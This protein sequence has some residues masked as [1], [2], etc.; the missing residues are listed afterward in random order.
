MDMDRS[1]GHELG[2]PW[3]LTLGLNLLVVGVVLVLVTIPFELISSSGLR[4]DRLWRQHRLVMP[5]VWGVFTLFRVWDRHVRRWL[6][7]AYGLRSEVVGASRIFACVIPV[8]DARPSARV[9]EASR[10]LEENFPDVV[11][12][13]VGTLGGCRSRNGF[14]TSLTQLRS[15]GVRGRESQVE[16]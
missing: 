10:F 14:A 3:I 6:A 12:A 5:F 11:I 2:E 8:F 1:Q 7:L 13:Q 4:L 9:V 16:Q 15:C